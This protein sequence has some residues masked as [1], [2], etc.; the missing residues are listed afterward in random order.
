M[1]PSQLIDTLLYPLLGLVAF[2]WLGTSVYLLLAGLNRGRRALDLDRARKAL[3]EITIP[4]N[5]EAGLRAAIASL[6]AG[7]SDDVLLRFATDVTGDPLRDRV[8]ADVAV[9]R[10]GA[11]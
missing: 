11:A 7:L 9:A 5:D 3:S 4:D 10:I 6:V 8:L 2:T 1:T